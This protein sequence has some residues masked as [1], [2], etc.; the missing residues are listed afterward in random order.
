MSVFIT[1]ELFDF[2]FDFDFAP[3]TDGGNLH[4]ASIDSVVGVSSRK[5][6]HESPR[7]GMVDRE[8]Q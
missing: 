5:V 7:T 4:F 1:G 8:R 6:L 2:D 3:K